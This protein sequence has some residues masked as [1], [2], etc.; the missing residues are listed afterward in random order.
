[1]I[2]HALKQMLSIQANQQ[3]W[4]LIGEHLLKINMKFWSDSE[5]GGYK[6]ED[7]GIDV[8]IKVNWI[9]RR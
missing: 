4:Q 2:N 8:K 3:I 1:L 9:L 7:Q 6:L 5:K